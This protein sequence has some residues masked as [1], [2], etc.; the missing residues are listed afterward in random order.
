MW[1]CSPRDS[2]VHS[3]TPLFKSINSSPL[4]LLHGPTLVSIHDYWKNCSFV[5]NMDLYCQSNF[6]MLFR[7]VIAF[8]PRSTRL[9]ISC[10]VSFNIVV[11]FPVLT[12]SS[13]PSYRFLRRQGRW[14]GSPISL[15]IFQFVVIH[16]AKG[17]HVV[18]E[19][20]V[21]IFL[22]FPCFLYDPGNVDNLM[23]VPLPFLNPGLYICKFSVQVLLKTS[24]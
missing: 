11:S 18:N 15:R 12:V 16:T 8:L 19:A 2:Q 5:Y 10:S 22:E 6:N 4:S 21:D 24:L 17:F 9:L 3:P 14:S 13:W 23:S 20:E 7:F 1:S